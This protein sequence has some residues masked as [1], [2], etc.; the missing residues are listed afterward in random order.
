MSKRDEFGME[1]MMKQ[2]AGFE[3]DSEHDEVEVLVKADEKNAGG[4]G[5]KKNSIAAKNPGKKTG[6]S[7]K[8]QKTPAAKNRSDFSPTPIRRSLLKWIAVLHPDKSK[9]DSVDHILKEYVSKNKDK[10]ARAMTET[11]NDMD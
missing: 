6:R 3:L 8:K 9:Q 5:Q 1:E 10:I 2:V 7:K 4:E 11:L